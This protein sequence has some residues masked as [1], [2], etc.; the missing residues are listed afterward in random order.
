MAD[1]TEQIGPTSVAADVMAR[2]LTDAV[3]TEGLLADRD[4]VLALFT[5][6]E[7]GEGL[8]M[9]NL[10]KSGTCRT[11]LFHVAADA[12]PTVWKRHLHPGGEI[13]VVLFGSYKDADQVHWATTV[14][15]APAGSIHAPEPND[16]ET[17]L[18]V[19]W[20]DGVKILA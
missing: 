8:R 4:D 2:T 1:G 19:V 16:E 6:I 5:W 12:P 11:V 9:A 20:P 17:L 18:L 3:M 13:T 7:V 15:F 10:G 14:Q